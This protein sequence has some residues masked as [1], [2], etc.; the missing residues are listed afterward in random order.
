M[1]ADDLD[2]FRHRPRREP[3]ESQGH[4]TVS[5]P[6]TPLWP[7]FHSGCM[8]LFSLAVYK[9]FFLLQLCQH[10]LFD[11][12]L[13]C[14]KESFFF[15]F[16]WHSIM[17]LFKIKKNLGR[18]VVKMQ[19]R[20]LDFYFSESSNFHTF[21]YFYNKLFVSLKK[22]LFTFSFFSYYQFTAIH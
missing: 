11:F 13:S 19:L 22:I 16:N 12:F 6:P 21:Y 20:S 14:L 7:G 9:S 17:H 8:S 2:S 10:S 4:S 18:I 3:A 15:L 5:V 1:C